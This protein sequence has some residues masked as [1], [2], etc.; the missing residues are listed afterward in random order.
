M[1]Y[2]P[3]LAAAALMLTLRGEAYAAP[4]NETIHGVIAGSHTTDP[5]GY[6][7]TAG[8]DLKGRPFTVTLS[9]EPED[10]NQGGECRN[11][12]CDYH[13]ASGTAA[14]PGSVRVAVQIGDVTQSYAPKQVGIVFLSIS[15][16]PFIAID[17]DCDSGFGGYGRGVQ[18]SVELMNNPM[19]GSALSPKNPALTH[20]SSY[21]NI[22]FFDKSAQT[23]AEELT[24]NV[25]S[26][27][28]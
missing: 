28:P 15:G 27:A 7:G 19:F 5:R 21:D 23:P 6:F 13:E 3:A 14:V 18:A 1:R 20:R 22:L 24:L 10:F 11:K 16:Q 2:L 26:S 25:R 8:A 17:S 12:S 4:V 9:Y